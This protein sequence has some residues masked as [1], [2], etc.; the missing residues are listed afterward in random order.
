[1]N[2]ITLC[3]LYRNSG[4]GA[5]VGVNSGELSSPIV[6]KAKTY[7]SNSALLRGFWNPIAKD[8]N[9]CASLEAI[10]TF[11]SSTNPE[12]SVALYAGPFMGPFSTS[13]FCLREAY[14]SSVNRYGD[15][16][17][18]CDES[19]ISDFATGSDLS[20]MTLHEE[21]LPIFLKH[22]FFF[23]RLYSLFGDAS[24]ADSVM[25]YDEY[26]VS[27]VLHIHATI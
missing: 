12:Y 22:L 3:Q 5:A 18:T 16:S 6:N 21:E 20:S 4:M 8:S 11:L 26:R 1:M 9:G 14:K 7:F 17:S 19:V 10:H 23:H 13:K 2:I 27:T 25:T 15:S 24:K